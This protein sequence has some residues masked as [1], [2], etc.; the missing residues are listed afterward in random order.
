[1][2]SEFS[3]LYQK[4]FLHASMQRV[5]VERVF[6]QG[7]TIA[8][9]N[10]KIEQPN[11]LSLSS[12]LLTWAIGLLMMQSDVLEKSAKKTRMAPEPLCDSTGL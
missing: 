7:C 5:T 12:F 4:L 3:M 2:L 1:M 10:K 11:R 8:E 6:N 9:K